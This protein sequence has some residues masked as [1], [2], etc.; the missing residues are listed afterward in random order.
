M[1]STVCVSVVNTFCQITLQKDSTN[2]NCTIEATKHGAPGAGVAALGPGR[3]PGAQDESRI[4]LR[5][6]SLPLPLP[7]SL[8]LS[9]M[10]K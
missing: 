6:G 9:L 3:D 10:N 5:A 1:N 4:G 2:L 7:G 8:T